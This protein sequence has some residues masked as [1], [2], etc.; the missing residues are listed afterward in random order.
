MYSHNCFCQSHS[1]LLSNTVGSN[2][3]YLTNTSDSFNNFFHYSSILTH[4]HLESNFYHHWALWSHALFLRLGSSYKQWVT[5]IKPL[6]LKFK[7]VKMHCKSI[8]NPKYSPP[9]FNNYQHSAFSTQFYSSC[10]NYNN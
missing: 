4:H 9:N 8:T 5:F 1:R 10:D 3:K 7:H 2:F 6:I